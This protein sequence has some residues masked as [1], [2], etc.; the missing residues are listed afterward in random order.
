MQQQPAATDLVSQLAL[1]TGKETRL[2]PVVVARTG[3]DNFAAFPGHHCPEIKQQP[4][5]YNQ[6]D[7]HFQNGLRPMCY[8]SFLELDNPNNDQGQADAH[9]S[10]VLDGYEPFQFAICVR[11]AI[12]SS[13]FNGQQCFLRSPI[14]STYASCNIPATDNSRGDS[15]TLLRMTPAVPVLVPSC[16]ITAAPT[17]R[18]AHKSWR[19]SHPSRPC[20]PC[21]QRQKSE[22]WRKMMKMTSW[23]T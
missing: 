5:E 17:M 14:A 12:C 15:P 1:E 10:V 13:V 19:Y 18:T 9:Q 20:L 11:V 21:F 23:V 6:G 2:C 8:C 3:S 16:N 7:P 22:G 4:R